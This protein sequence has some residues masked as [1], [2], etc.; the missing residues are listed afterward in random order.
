MAILLT[1]TDMLIGGAIQSGWALRIADGLIEFVGP[2]D[3][4]ASGSA[5]VVD[6]AGHIIAPGFIDTQ[7]N[8]GGGAMFCDEPT[9]QTLEGMVA[10]H[11]PYGT[12]AIMPT[13]ITSDLDVCGA[14]L[15]Q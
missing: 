13:L 1:D 5:E 4:I 11:R 2:A 9:V 12:T 10:A 8:G 15:M 6:L 7:V 3:E 14:R